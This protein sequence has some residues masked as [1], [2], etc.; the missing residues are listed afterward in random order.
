[1]QI[2]KILKYIVIPILW[3]IPAGLLAFSILLRV[4]TFKDVNK[5]QP[6]EMISDMD[7]GKALKPQSSNPFFAN[8]GAEALRPINSISRSGKLYSVEQNDIEGASINGENPL[9]KTALIYRYGKH[10]FE[11]N[12]VYCHNS[13]GDGQGAIITKMVLKKDE[14]PFP[15]PPDIRTSTVS[16]SPDSR[17]FHILSAGQNLMYPVGYK[18]TKTDRWA[19]IRYFRTLQGVETYVK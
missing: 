9:P 4:D 16:K 7:N 8:K 5:N 2:S 10:L 17:L 19:V 15:G 6:F 3:L 18:L 12:C 1:M 13:N 11:T 14:E